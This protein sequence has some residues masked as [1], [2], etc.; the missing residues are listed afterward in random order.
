MYSETG[1]SPDK[2]SVGSTSKLVLGMDSADVEE[3]EDVDMNLE[4]DC[5]K[6]DDEISDNDVQ[7][8]KE[9]S[10]SSEQE[11]DVED[12]PEEIKIKR[13]PNPADPTPAERERHNATHLPYRPWCSICVKA[14]GKEDPHYR[15]VKSELQSGIPEAAMDYASLCETRDKSD[16]IR[17]MIGKERWTKSFFCHKVK[18]K[19]LGDPYIVTNV[20]K[21]IETMGH[22]KIAL[23]TDGEPAIVQV[24]AEIQK[25][26][27]P[28][29]TVPRNPPAYDP[30]SNGLAERAVGQ[31]K[32]QIRALKLGL[33]ARLKVCIDLREPIVDWITRHAA[34]LLNNFHV[35]V[36]GRTAYF[37]I[38]HK[39]FNGKVFEIGEQV[40]AK[41]K[42][43]TNKSKSNSTRARWVEG[44]WVGWDERTGEHIVVLSTGQAVRIRSVRPLPESERW[45]A[46]AVQAMKATPNVPNPKDTEQRDPLPAREA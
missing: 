23:T 5:E 26:R 35:G 16:K 36:D 8:E 29:M 12:T 38:H 17:L 30:Q 41:P 22:T 20:V 27:S 40:L 1:V 25:K 18:C 32:G 10:E 42:R 31:V 7:S 39:N 33:E 46:K 15:Q 28:L 37:R 9:N 14:N 3:E 45:N 21:S 13:V 11:F 19:G 6:E 34:S 43:R 2:R 44:T 4:D 24:Q